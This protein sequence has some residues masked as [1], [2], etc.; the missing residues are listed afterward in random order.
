MGRWIIWGLC[1]AGLF[2]VTAPARAERAAVVR[3]GGDPGIAEPVRREAFAKVAELLRRQGLEVMPA[4]EAARRAAAA[5]CEGPGCAVRLRAALGVDLLATV[6]LWSGPDSGLR[7]VVVGLVDDA[8][9]AGSADVGEG[10]LAAA[11]ERAL[12]IARSRQALGPGPWLRVEG[13][14]RGALVVVDGTEWGVLPSEAAAREG[15]HGVAVRL[16]GYVTEER[17]VRLHAGAGEPV[18]LTV[19]LQPAQRVGPSPATQTRQRPVPPRTPRAARIDRPV[20]GPLILGGAGVGALG[21]AL[22][23]ALTASCDRVAS[24]GTCLTGS[25]LDVG[26]AAGYTIGGAAAITAAILWHMLGGTRRPVRRVHVGLAPGSLVVG[27]QGD[28]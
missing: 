3:L 18:V 1:V 13:E 11:L 25:Q 19:R 5:R 27:W 21:V 24:D 23:A 16:D 14:P 8:S 7:S 26:L 15:E 4:A 22:G 20:I 28:L 6:G 2:L 10:G 12:T 17:T 9:Y